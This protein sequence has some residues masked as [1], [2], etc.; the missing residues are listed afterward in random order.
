M[1]AK[2]VK[3]Q[4][5][6]DLESLFGELPDGIQGPLSSCGHVSSESWR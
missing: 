2:L 5:L 4:Q 3:A 1:A 6:R